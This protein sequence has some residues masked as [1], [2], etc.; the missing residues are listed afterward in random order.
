M[1]TLVSVRVRE[2]GFDTFVSVRFREREFDMFVSVR[3]RV[4]EFDMFV[5]VRVRYRCVSIVE[6]LSV[7]VNNPLLESAVLVLE[8]G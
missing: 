7:R 2:R 4:Y 8:R 3:S 5:G 1:D 6:T